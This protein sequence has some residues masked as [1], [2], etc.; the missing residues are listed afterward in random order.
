MNEPIYSQNEPSL[1][2]LKLR[3]ELSFSLRTNNGKAFMLVHDALHSRY[4]RLGTDEWKIVK[5]FDGR[6]TLRQVRQNAVELV[7]EET[8]S[9]TEVGRL[10]N[11]LVQCGLAECTEGSL[12]SP[13]PTPCTT[14]GHR[15][16]EPLNK[17]AQLGKWNPLFL[18]ISLPNPARMLRY[19]Y[20]TVA[21]LFSPYLVPV[22]LVVCMFGGHSIFSQ[23]DRF[24]SSLQDVFAT[25]NWIYLLSVWIVLKILHEMGHAIACLRYGGDVTRC[26]LMLIVFSPIAW[27]DVTSSWSFRSKWQRIFVSAAGM[28]VEFFLAAIAAIIWAQTSDPLVATLMH[29]IVLSASVTTLLF[30]LN[31]LMRF[32]GYYILSDLMEIQNLYAAGRQSTQQLIRRSLLGMSAAL[33]NLPKNK[34]AIVRAYG[35]AAMIWRITFCVGILIVA[36]HLFHGAGIVLALFSG[37]IWFAIPILRFGLLLWHGTENEQPNRTRFA[38]I[39]G[40]CLVAGAACMALPWPGTT[41]AHGVVEFS[42]LRTVRVDSS[43]FVQEISVIPGQDVDAGDVLLRLENSALSS[44]LADIELQIQVQQIARRVN[45][46]DNDMAQYSAVGKKLDS[47]HE[48]RQQLV[49]KVNALNVRAPIDGTLIANSLESLTGKYVES[50]TELLS[51]GSTGE[52]EVRISIQQQDI[53]AF[54]NRDNGG[55]SI[56]VTGHALPNGDAQLKRLIPKATRRVIHFALAATSGGPLAVQQNPNE[57]SS[58]HFLLVEPRFEGVIA[59]PKSLSEE[60]RAGEVCRVSLGRGQQKVYEKLWTFAR[61]YFERK[62]QRGVL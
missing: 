9:P 1:A 10:A 8:A 7:G 3:S 49:A 39:G 47:L 62:S 52:K 24:R 34:L 50:G 41:I 37:A 33:P 13:A 28:Y 42:P 21:W 46:R 35:L 14:I 58:D 44:K 27:V 12:N 15:W 6:T 53:E 11:W 2:K 57:Q 55:V 56:G 26:G 23:W 38:L 48:Q 16:H 36:A 45:H 25:E 29:N 40:V 54:R 4:Y 60:L 32:D 5:L 31:F 30:N 59:I 51:V 43:G 17:T 22:W 61:S 19:A 18:N 20:P